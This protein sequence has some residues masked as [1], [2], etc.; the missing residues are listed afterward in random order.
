[1]SALAVHTQLP[2]DLRVQVDRYEASGERSL[3]LHLRPH[4]T[5][6]APDGVWVRF[7]APQRVADKARVLRLLLGQAASAHGPT[8]GEIDVRAPDNPVLVPAD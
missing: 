6:A 5:T 8:L 4:P 1:R 2:A 3:R 7:G